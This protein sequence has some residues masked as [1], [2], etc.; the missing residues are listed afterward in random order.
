MKTAPMIPDKLGIAYD[1]LVDN[2]SS[3][4]IFV[5]M[6]DSQAYPKYLIQFKIAK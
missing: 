1:T 4:T 3:P 5:A 6:R 2:T